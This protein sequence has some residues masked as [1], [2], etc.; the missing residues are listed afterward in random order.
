VIAKEVHANGRLTD[1]NTRA[2]DA[3][4][5]ARLRASAGAAG[6]TVAELAL[7]FVLHHRHI[8]IA[9]SGA[10]TTAQLGSHAAAA[11][12]PLDDATA[13]SLAS[14]AEAPASYWATRGSLPWT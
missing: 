7:A 13:A 12:A 8:D 1:A 11:T 3:P 2:A 4:L 9:R 6:T 10:A 5:L 14:S